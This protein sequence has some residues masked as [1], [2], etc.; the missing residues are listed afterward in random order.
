MRANFIVLG[1]T[2]VLSSIAW[3]QGAKPQIDPTHF[4]SKVQPV[5]VAHCYS[6][7]SPDAKKAKGD[8]RIDRLAPDFANAHSREGWLEV[9]KRVK[10]KEMPPKSKP[11]P[12][13][14]ETQI[15]ME[16]ITAGLKAADA[17][18]V[19][20][21]RVVLRRLNR[22]E[23]ENTVRDLLG[24]H[25]DLRDMLP[26]DTSAH[27]F[28]NIGD[29]LH[30]STFLMERYLDAAEHALNVAIANGPQPPLIKKR[31]SLKDSHQVKATTERVFRKL[32][33]DSV[34]M[35]S[36]S[37]WQAVTV[38]QFYPPDRG[39]YRFRISASG[40]QSAGKPVTFQVNAGLMLMAG[41]THL[42]GY[43]DALPDKPKV[44]EFI[45]HMEPR[46]SIRI[47][48]YGLAGANA[49]NK[50][51]ADRWDGPGLAIHWIEVEGPLHDTW[52]PLSHRRI[53]G[54]L[55]ICLN[56]RRRSSTSA[57]VWKWCRRIPKRMP[58]ASCATLHAERFAAT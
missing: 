37:A 33:D 57:I 29:A 42:V 11:Q 43:F 19:A 39:S 44:V 21:G 17:R 54:D 9:L 58:N 20:E 2:M 45:D 22:I 8:F 6:C 28:D 56:R 31:Y 13:E 47:L 41:K 24:V 16:W 30:T 12:T 1:L 51:G 27:G 48:P 5:L 18:R 23:Y 49:I 52:P 34:V 25:V 4:K 10:A 40:V 14:Q 53:F 36:S 38:Y 35:F 55:A 46:N 26:L 15:L 32:D 7:H 3:G 50:I